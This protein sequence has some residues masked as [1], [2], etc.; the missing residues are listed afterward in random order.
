MLRH[1]PLLRR[2]NGCEASSPGGGG[3]FFFPRQYAARLVRHRTHGKQIGAKDLVRMLF[4]VVP[5]LHGRSS[6]GG[7]GRSDQPA[8]RLA[9]I[10]A[11]AAANLLGISI[12]PVLSGAP[13]S[14]K[15]PG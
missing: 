9:N 12:V 1:L 13:R 10:P 4:L 15:S 5:L 3:A 7:T 6:R 8:C 2:S 11:C 14:R